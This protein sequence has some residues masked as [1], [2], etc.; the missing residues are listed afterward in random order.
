ML[1]LRGTPPVC[2]A[3]ASWR[4]HWMIHA[5]ETVEPYGRHTFSAFVGALPRIVLCI[6]LHRSSDSTDDCSRAL[7]LLCRPPPVCLAR[8][9]WH[10][11][12]VIHAV[13]TVE[14]YG[15]H[16][17]SAFVG[18]LPRIVLCITLHR[19]RD[20]TVDCRALLLLCRT[21][22]V[23]LARGSWHGDWMIHAVGTLL[24]GTPPVCLA[25][26]SWHRD[27][28]IHVV[29]TVEPYRRHTFSA[30]VGAL[31]QI[32]LCITLHRYSDNTVDCSRAVFLLCGTPPVC[33][34]RASWHRDWLIH[35]AET[36]LC[37]IPPVCLARASWHR[38]WMIHAVETV[39]LY[40]RHTFSAFVGA[41]PRI[42]L[43]LT[44]HR[45]SDSTVDCSRALLLLCGPPL[46]CLA[47]ASWRRHWMI[48]A[49]V[50]G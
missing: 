2:L 9:S 40:R 20:S 42:V 36:L 11:D 41:L 25:R 49:A 14:P 24:C 28:V 23:C 1:L 31:P 13:E 39:E 21:P 29:E 6:T 47:R 12:W 27:W 10:R 46:V 15:R 17:F 48:H 43:C 32:V 37:G 50:T 33:L 8:A 44:L 38:D 45:S 18:A 19:S 7:L 5:V 30:F 35:A 34:A 22:P 4:R 3:R 16:T 26:A